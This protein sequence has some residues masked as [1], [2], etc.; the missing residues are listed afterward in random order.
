[1]R[2]AEALRDHLPAVAELFRRGDLSARVVSAITWRTRLVT[3][4][5]VWALID[6]ELAQR[7]MQWGPLAGGQP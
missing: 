1:M 3:D 5:A 4:D 2:I 6:T 7:A